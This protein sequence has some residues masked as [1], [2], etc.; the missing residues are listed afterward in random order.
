MLIITVYLFQY[1]VKCW[2]TWRRKDTFEK[3]KTS[4]ECSTMIF[5]PY[6]D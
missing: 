2:Q 1:N 3:L 6:P 4:D 5:L